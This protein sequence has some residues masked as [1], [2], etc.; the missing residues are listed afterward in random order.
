MAKRD[1]CRRRDGI[2]SKLIT[3]TILEKKLSLSTRISYFSDVAY[4]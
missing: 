3:N 1:P 2:V 4:N